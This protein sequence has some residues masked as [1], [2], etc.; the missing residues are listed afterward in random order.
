MK[1][2][3]LLSRV[4]YPLEKGD[5]LRAF[6]QIK[7]LARDHK[8]V[9]CCIND[10]KLHPDALK[11]LEPYCEEIR[12]IR[13]H[14]LSIYLRVFLGLFS[15]KPLQ[16]SYFY[17]QKAQ[18]II[19]RLIEKHLPKHVY[20]QLVRIAEYALKYSILPKTLDYMDALSTGAERRLQSSPFYLRPILRLEAKRLIAYESEV[21]DHFQHHTIISEQDRELIGHPRK[22][23][24][25]IIPNGVD[26]DF[27]Q[28]KANTKDFDLVFTGNMSYPPNVMAARYIVNEILP[29][30]LAQQ[31]NI[32][33][34][35]AGASP[36][37]AVRALH[38]ENVTISGWVADIRDAYNRSKILLA[39]MQIGTGLQNKLLEGMAMK[40][41][42]I[43][44]SLANNALRAPDGTAVLIGNTPQEYAKLVLD[45]LVDTER[46]S[47]LQENGYRFVVKHYN[48]PQ[49]TDRLQAI[50]TS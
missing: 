3:V 5:K 12:I 37:P 41:P 36:A 10:R 4:P 48:W 49:T 1:I 45:L 35:I 34:L 38:S 6:N 18:R 20:C 17:N 14:R 21:F 23:E 26:L 7:W 31:P 22:K 29:L 2:L 32:K 13:I 28:A 16:V 15:S 47:L 40:V 46:Y 44:S 50:M 27:F 30:L 9:L 8:I 43:T 39:P 25:E 24:I 11:V 33:V 42:C 19:D